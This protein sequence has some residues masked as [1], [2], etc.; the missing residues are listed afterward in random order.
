MKQ[1]KGFVVLWVIFFLMIGLIG[2]LDREGMTVTGN[3]PLTGILKEDPGQVVQ[4]QDYD[5]H[6]GIKEK[7]IYKLRDLEF[8][9]NL[10]PKE[11]LTHS[12]DISYFVLNSEGDIL[13]FEDE[14]Q[15]I[16]KEV[17]IER[18]LDNRAVQEL[19]LPEGEY[20]LGLSISYDSTKKTFSEKFTLEKISEVLYSLKQLFDIKLE[21]DSHSL[22]KSSDLSA[23]VVFENFGGEN[24]PVN[25]TFFI[26]DMKDNEL[27]KKEMSRVVQTEDSV[28]QSFKDFEA[29]AGRYRVVLRT[30][31]NVGVEDYFEAEFVVKEKTDTLPFIVIGIL[32]LIGGYFIFRPVKQKR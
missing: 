15:T 29:P 11:S 30:L 14:S 23:R 18:D 5:I 3:V 32:L 16:S 1:W 20:T 27:Y 22:K 21:L 9:I 7:L 12:V 13:Y 31:Y 10:M 2:Y 25:L 26:Y 4:T 6:F 24:T 28:I 19:E 17:L 8:W